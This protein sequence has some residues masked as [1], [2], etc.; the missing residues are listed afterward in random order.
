M[1]WWN[2]AIIYQIY[3]RSFNN[4][5]MGVIDK[6]PYLKNVLKIDAI[7][8]NPFFPDGN[9]DGGYDVKNY[10]SINP[11]FGT[12]NNFKLMS[13]K[14]KENDIK[15][16]IDIPFSHTSNQHPW[17]LDS[18]ARK[19]NKE[20][21]YIW[22]DKKNI[23]NNWKSEF[24]ESPWTYNS[25]RDQ[26]YYHY[27]YK[28]QPAL[29]IQNQYVQNEIY[30][31]IN[32]WHI[33]GVNGIRLD[34]ISNYI[35]DPEFKPNMHSSYNLENQLNTKNTIQFIKNLS[36]NVKKNISED[37]LLIGEQHPYFTR[38]EQ[39]QEYLTSLDKIMNFNL[40]YT[41][42]LDTEIISNKIINKSKDMI[43][44]INNHDVVRNRYGEN[45]PL[46]AKLMATLLLSLNE[47]KII[48]YGQE[49]G[50]FN[51]KNYGFD[52]I[53]RDT[54]RSPMQWYNDMSKYK[55]NKKW[56]PLDDNYKIRNVE[57]QLE[58]ENSILQ[59]YIKLIELSKKLQGHIFDL[60]FDENILKFKRNG[61]DNNIYLFI[62]NFS[63]KEIYNQDCAL[64]LKPYSSYIILNESIMLQSI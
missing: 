9:R 49:I 35:V 25:S 11:L 7:W 51:G 44:F 20:N 54:A 43:C 53:G 10:Y 55:I 38:K 31:I 12:L 63:N 13:Q 36:N 17:F 28:E 45:N 24:E 16:I 23:V 41:N 1:K 52:K 33:M 2:T 18:I 47:T 62:L 64:I 19:N 56:I 46:I 37:L 30:K 34:A 14:L 27:Y 58:N 42:K 5:F 50:M 4:D 60:K 21:W 15:I 48:Y 39:E 59:W 3:L 6:I 22:K 57:D 61:E 8:F 26:Y 32:F 29:N 40:A